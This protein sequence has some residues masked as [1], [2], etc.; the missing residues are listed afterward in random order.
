MTPDLTITIG[1]T[2]Q[3]NITGIKD[4]NGF[5]RDFCLDNHYQISVDAG[6]GNHQFAMVAKKTVT[7]EAP[8]VDLYL[9][10]VDRDAGNL[11]H[12]RAMKKGEHWENE[13]GSPSGCCQGNG[14]TI[15][16]AVTS[17]YRQIDQ[18]KRMELLAKLNASPQ[19]DTHVLKE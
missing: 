14:D 6:I 3:I 4:A 15:M 1:R 17:L 16:D 19:Q 10:I 9:V 11:E 18:V 12:W 13:D 8:D 2:E 7:T 5:A